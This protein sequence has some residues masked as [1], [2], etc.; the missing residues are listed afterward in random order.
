MLDEAT[1]HLDVQ[2]ESRVNDAIKHMGSTRVIIA[3]RRE[4]I[5]SADRV[6]ELN[7]PGHSSYE[8]NQGRNVGAANSTEVVAP[9]GAAAV[10][11]T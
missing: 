5:A 7:R 4:T 9:H 8:V 3:H 10:A 11:V 6:I 2:S 1:S